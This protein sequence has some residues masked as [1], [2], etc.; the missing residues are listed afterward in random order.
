MSA[1]PVSLEALR[2]LAEVMGQRGLSFLSKATGLPEP[3]L[4]AAMSGAC[5]VAAKKLED[6]AKERLET[7]ER[8]G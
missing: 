1:R 7:V 4:L 3:E 8:K 5:T 2:P 6:W